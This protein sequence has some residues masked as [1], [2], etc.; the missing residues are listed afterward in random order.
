MNPEMNRRELMALGAGVLA[1]VPLRSQATGTAPEMGLVEK[2]DTLVADKLKL[3][4]TDPQSR[5]RGGAPNAH[6]LYHARE[7]GELLEFFA[8][9]YYHPESRYYK[10]T[11]LV[12]RMKQAIKFLERYQTEDGNTDLLVTNFNSPPDTG[13]VIHRAGTAA[14]LAK[15]N[16]DDE[17]LGMMENF[18]RKAGLGMAKGGIH[19]PNHRWVVAAALAQIHDVYPDERFVKRMETWLAEGIDIDEEG[20][21]VERS[22]GGYNATVDN[23]LVTVALLSERKDVLD[24]VRKNLDAMSYLLHSNGD[25]V[26]EISRRQDSNTRQTMSRYWFALRH[27]A[28]Q[29]QNGLYASMLEPLEPTYMRLPQ[30]MAYEELRGELPKSTPIPD[31]YEIDYPISKITRIRRGKSSATLMHH[32]NSRWF[33][34][35]HG[36]AVINAVRFSSAFFGKGQFSP[37]KYRHEGDAYIFEQRLNGVYYQPLTDPDLLPLDHPGWSRTKGKRKLSEVCNL[38]YRGEIRE[39]ETGYTL[40]IE[41][42]GTPNSPCAIEINLREGGALKGVDASP[43]EGDSYLLKSGMAEYRMGEDVLR[44]GPGQCEHLYTQIRGAEDKLSGPSVYITGYTPFKY[45]L[46]IELG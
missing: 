38:N 21:Y 7:G 4:V 12:E 36:K 8:A 43:V 33:A 15:L 14:R 19:T 9:A 26:T 34:L 45:Q 35:H 23:A 3:Q 42:S 24:A 27:M 25:V 18:I 6:M 37:A 29:D 5:W 2:H 32:R 39:T 22:T 44:F 40:D 31:N 17:V 41:A 1:S 11:E 10:Q 20:Q 30:M 16:G 46:R 13:F 28:I